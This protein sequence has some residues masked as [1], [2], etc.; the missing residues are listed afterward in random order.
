MSYHA[1]FRFLRAAL[2]V[3]ALSYGF[4][5]ILSV[6]EVS[7]ADDA[8]AAS[9]RVTSDLGAL[10]VSYYRLTNDLGLSTVEQHGFREATSWAFVHVGGS[11]A[12]AVAINTE[13]PKAF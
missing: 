6:H 4:L 7:A 12:T 8:R 2:V 13:A 10:E 3:A 1:S 5:L 9:R 11:D